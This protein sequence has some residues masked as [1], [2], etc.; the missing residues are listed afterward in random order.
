M[1]WEIKLSNQQVTPWS[2]LAFMRRM[3]DKMGF[4]THLSSSG[5]LPQLG[6]NRG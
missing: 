1:D 5:V 3:L 6:S 2:G 4:S